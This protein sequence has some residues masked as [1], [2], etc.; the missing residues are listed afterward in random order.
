M[1]ILRKITVLIT[2]LA[3]MGPMLLHVQAQ[4][5][6]D[7]QRQEIL[8]DTEKA[9]EQKAK[10]ILQESFF[11]NLKS[12]VGTTCDLY[13]FGIDFVNYVFDGQWS[14]LFA[15]LDI[16]DLFRNETWRELIW[17]V[18][19]KRDELMKQLAGASKQDC[20]LNTA[21]PG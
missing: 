12:L 1:K 16:L 6:A 4:E 10:G 8:D 20:V 15:I 19:D 13:A 17:A 21:V 18:S 11:N 2:I 7:E 3:L 14:P 5:T 9:V